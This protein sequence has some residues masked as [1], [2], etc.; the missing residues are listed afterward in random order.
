MCVLEGT[1][2][3]V[4]SRVHVGGDEALELHTRELDR[5]FESREPELAGGDLA[6]GFFGAANFRSE[7][8]SVVPLLCVLGVQQCLPGGFVVFADE[9]PDIVDDPLV[10]VLTTERIASRWASATAKSCSVRVSTAASI[11]PPPKS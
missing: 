3:G 10:D 7:R 11:V 2:Q 1:L 6:E 4:H 9:C 8:G 5:P